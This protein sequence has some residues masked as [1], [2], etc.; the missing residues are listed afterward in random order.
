MLA[1]TES[2]NPSVEHS[3]QAALYHY[4]NHAL[5]DCRDACETAL[6]QLTLSD[7]S[8]VEISETSHMQ[9]L[10]ILLLLFNVYYDAD[11]CKEA[12]RMLATASGYAVEH[13]TQGN[14]HNNKGLQSYKTALLTSTISYNR[15]LIY[16]KRY[17]TDMNKD[18]KQLELALEYLRESERG[19]LNVLGR[20]RLLLAS[21]W[22]TMGVCYCHLP[23]EEKEA[24][25]ASNNNKKDYA[26]ALYYFTKSLELRTHYDDASG[27][28][29]GQLANTL[30][31]IAFI[32]SKVADGVSGDSVSV[33]GN[34]H[35]DTYTG[36]DEARLLREKIKEIQSVVGKTRREEV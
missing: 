36:D 11:A 13:L 4:T 28:V 25:H 10:H 34:R 17:E 16:I 29:Q 1:E 14:N 21:V 15:A 20:S 23:L 6:A 33:F 27:A 35:D 30:E 19:M 5:D 24:N 26:K 22:H 12:E 9:F 2:V 18:Y 3:Y 32:Y 8:S 7:R 31:H